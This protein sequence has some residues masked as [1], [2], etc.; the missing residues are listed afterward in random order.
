[1]ADPPPAPIAINRGTLSAAQPPERM[2]SDHS[3]ATFVLVAFAVLV[4]LFNG[5]FA[6]MDWQWRR[7]ALAAEGEVLEI[8]GEQS[9]IARVRYVDA[10][11]V[12]RIADT[13]GPFNGVQAE[14]GDRIAILYHA[15]SPAYA[16]HDDPTRDWMGTAMFAGVGALLL[17]PIPFMWRQVRR[18]EQR[19]ARL[20]AL[21]YK[22]S[23]DSVRTEQVPWGK[24]RRWALVA[25]WR[26]SLGR[27]RQTL[28][29]PYSYDPAPVDAASLV[30]LVDPQAPDQSA[31]APETLPKFSYPGPTRA[32]RAR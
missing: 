18:Q 21:G 20:R 27:T 15:G 23:V 13:T 11:G 4:Q 16:S 7:H 28:A 29:G 31:V 9:P 1:M 3:L 12:E 10:K 2:R 30:I 32:A 19:Y 5:G 6:L 14:V 24:F 8:V 25:T 22:R 26:D 17:L